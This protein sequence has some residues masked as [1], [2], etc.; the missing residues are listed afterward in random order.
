MWSETLGYRQ[1]RLPFTPAFLA[2]LAEAVPFSRQDDVLDLGSGPGEIAVQIAP[3]ARTVTALDAEQPMLDE[4]ALRAKAAGRDIRRVRARAEEAPVD[5]GPFKLITI[6]NAHQF[7][8]HPGTFERLNRWLAPGGRIAICRARDG[9]T[10]GWPALLREVHRK[11][12][13]DHSGRT[14]MTAGEFFAG[15]PFDADKT[16]SI[17]GQQKIDLN[18]LLLRAQA[19]STSAPAVLGKERTEAMLAELRAALASYFRNGPLVEDFT[20]QAELY[21]RRGDR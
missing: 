3:L 8:H 21:R 18:H 15:T 5:L 17:Q 10:P 14:R 2:A 4:L 9:T 7:M 13:N 20:N 19:Y 6:A 1:C 11:W 12:G 16:I